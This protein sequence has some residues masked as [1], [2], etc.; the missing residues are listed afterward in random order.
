MA[1]PGVSY[2]SRLS[3][4]TSSLLCIDKTTGTHHSQ[5][6]SHIKLT[7][8]RTSRL[9][10]AWGC[11][12]SLATALVGENM[13][14]NVVCIFHLNSQFWVHSNTISQSAEMTPIVSTQVQLSNQPNI[15][16]H[17]AAVTRQL[18]AAVQMPST[19][20][21]GRASIPGTRRPAM[22]QESTSF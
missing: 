22:R 21:L 17:P 4:F 12:Q 3:M 13:A 15:A 1:V 6:S 16:I 19:I 18:S 2:V 10:I 5:E 9:R 20:T 7:W 8:R 11:A 14:I